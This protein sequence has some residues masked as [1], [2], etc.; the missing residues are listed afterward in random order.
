MVQ[1]EK[2]FWILLTA[3]IFAINYNRRRKKKHYLK[4]RYPNIAF[5]NKALLDQ[6]LATKHLGS[7]KKHIYMRNS[8]AGK[9]YA[10]SQ[11]PQACTIEATA[12]SKLPSRDKGRE[13]AAKIML[14]LPLAEDV[15][16]P[17]D[18]NHP[19]QS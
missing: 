2:V 14:Q 1:Q 8:L 18:N 11:D 19:S 15:S 4:E 3:F 16:A 12:H 13:E 5:P 6:P 7:V 9:W 17:A 10:S